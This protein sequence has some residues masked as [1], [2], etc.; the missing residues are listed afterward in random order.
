MEQLRIQKWLSL[1][2][3]ASRREAESWISEGRIAVNGRVIREFGVKVTPNKDQITIDG[4]LVASGTPPRVYWMLNKP[5]AV[6]T[7]R[8]DGLLRPTIYDLPKLQRVPFLISPVGRL[9]F[10]T[11]GLLLLTNDG[12]LANR[13]CHP[14]YKVPRTYHVLI[15]GKLKDEELEKLAAGVQ[16]EDGPTQPAQV[17]YA[18]GKNLGASRGSW[19][20]V[21]V[22]EGRNRLV[23]RLFE[24]FG[25]KVV[26][27]IR[28]SFGALSMPQELAPGEYVQLNKDQI[29]TLRRAARLD[30]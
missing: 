21:T 9:D 30:S 4:K 12:E 5:D 18:H 13:L 15:S 28:V 26:R 19:Y 7:T 20:V 22:R 29:S 1:L 27:L 11:E 3:L 25:Y 10:R 14:S 24:H 6:M 23:R 16:L 8:K 2:G 17:R